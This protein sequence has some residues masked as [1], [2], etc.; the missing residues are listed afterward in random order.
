MATEAQSKPA[1]S[2]LE[3]PK[4]PEKEEE[5][6]YTPRERAFSGQLGLTRKK[7]SDLEERVKRI[8]ETHT[9]PKMKEAE[10]ERPGIMHEAQS[11][12]KGETFCKT[13]NQTMP[14]E[15][16]CKTCDTPLGSK[17]HASKLTKCVKPGCSGTK[18]V[19]IV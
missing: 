9:A 1:E 17:E 12:V 7:V 4:E 13:C 2:E 18:Y 8:E 16:K 5:G 10:P 19:P 11:S 14:N 3:A 6:K 15:V